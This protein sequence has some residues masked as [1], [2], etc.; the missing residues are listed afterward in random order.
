MAGFFLA[1]NLSLNSSVGFRGRQL[2]AIASVFPSMNISDAVIQLAKSDHM[3]WKKRLIDMILDRGEI[4]EEEVTDHHQCRFGK[5]YDT[6]GQ[7]HYGH[8]PGF[9]QLA[10]PHADVHKLAKSAVA[11]FNKGD[12]AGA[13]ADVEAIGPLSD[14]VVELLTTLEAH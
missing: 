11:K 13:V 4:R 9:T 2:D 7:E 6:A 8:A 3:L 14:T 10:T 12:K 1:R 5:W